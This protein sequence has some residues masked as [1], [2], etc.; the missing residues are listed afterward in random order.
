MVETAFISGARDLGILRPT[1]SRAL[2][3][4][5]LNAFTKTSLQTVRYSIRGSGM[6]GFVVSA[7]IGTY[8]IA[9]GNANF[10]MP[11]ILVSQC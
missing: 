6:I 11:W 9:N 7:G 10:L 2:A 5:T 4:R 8:N 3:K 1:S